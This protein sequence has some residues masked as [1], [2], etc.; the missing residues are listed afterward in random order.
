MKMGENV[1]DMDAPGEASRR[2]PLTVLCSVDNDFVN[3]VVPKLRSKGEMNE[4][5]RTMMRRA[6]LKTSN[7]TPHSGTSIRHG[8]VPLSSYSFRVPKRF[9]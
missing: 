3:L 7:P 9:S 6:L 2:L 5:T 4:T 8:V 1:S